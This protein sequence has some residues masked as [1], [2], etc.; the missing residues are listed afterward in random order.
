[1]L[2]LLLWLRGRIL[3]RD[4]ASKLAKPQNSDLFGQLA[5]TA[6]SSGSGHEKGCRS[7][8]AR[9]R[10]EAYRRRNGSRSRNYLSGHPGG[11]YEKDSGTAA[12]L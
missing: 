5:V 6:R 9:S 12:G 8:R 11:F 1:M 3:V 2:P 4:I 10:V 7:T